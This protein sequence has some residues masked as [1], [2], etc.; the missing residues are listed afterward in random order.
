MLGNKELVE[1]IAGGVVTLDEIDKDALP[2]EIQP[3]SSA[4]QAEYI[5]R[6]A[7]ERNELQRQILNLADNR[8]SFIEKKVEEA[9]GA[10]GS[11]DNKLYDV[12]SKQ[13]AEAGLELAEGP[14]Y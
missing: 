12:V 7:E 8:R 6:L 10:D 13:A 1:D 14:D 3:L 5:G 4:E 2:E 9:G 11:L